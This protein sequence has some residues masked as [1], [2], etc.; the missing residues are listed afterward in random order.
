VTWTDW[1]I[2]LAVAVVVAWL[3]LVV[4]LVIARPRGSVL[5]EALR[6]L[7]DLVPC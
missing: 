4:A 2:G 5:R 3:A 6:L 1:L 7:P